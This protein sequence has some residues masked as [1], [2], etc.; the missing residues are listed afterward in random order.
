MET[1]IAM[2]PFDV[3]LKSLDVIKQFLFYQISRFTLKT[4]ANVTEYNMRI[5][6]IM[7][8]I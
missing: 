8:R 2:V 5:N 3:K 7:R 1:N 6:A 4:Y